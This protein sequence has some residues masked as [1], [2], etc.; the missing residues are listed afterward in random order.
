MSLRVIAGAYRRRRLKTVT[1]RATRPYT[2]RV[3]QIVFDR[4][5]ETV[6][7]QRVADVFAGVGTMGIEALSRGAA[8]CVFIEADAEVH[9][10]LQENVTAIIAE[11]PCVCWKTDVF[12]TSFRPRN[13]E[14]C[15]PYDLVFFD[16]PYA[17]SE[18]LAPGRGLGAALK[19]L[20]RDSVTAADCRLLLR[21]PQ[22]HEFAGTAE[23]SVDDRWELSSMIIWKLRRD[24]SAADAGGPSSVPN[25]AQPESPPAAEL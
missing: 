6:I 25:L 3:R 11:Q 10:V 14:A 16:P 8:T 13:A 12:R 18:Q 1:S 20:A 17:M 2:D 15:L 23:W 7:G 22:K 19:R 9:R 21:T 4:L 5:G 24:G